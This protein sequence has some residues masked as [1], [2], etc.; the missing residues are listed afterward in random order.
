MTTCEPENELIRR[1]QQ[2]DGDAFAALYQLHAQTMLRTATRMLR[3]P[4]DAEDATQVAFV[5]LH[6]GI[7]NYNFRARFSTYLYRLVVNVCLDMLKKNKREDSD[8]QVPDLPS[9][10]HGELRLK[11]EQA[12]GTLPER[13]R[14]AFVLYAVEGVPQAEI[15]T[16]MDTSIGAVKAQVHQAKMRLR[17]LLAAPGREAAS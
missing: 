9:R 15:A 7:G 6:R 10:S 14:A 13:M 16:I 8:A 1:C 5:K 2:G 4:V 3:N 17:P 12:I 11:L